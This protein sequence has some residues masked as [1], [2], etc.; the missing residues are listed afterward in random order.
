[1][2]VHQF[3]KE[4]MLKEPASYNFVI[5]HFLLQRRYLVNFWCLAV[6]PCLYASDH[7]FWIG[8]HNDF[9]LSARWLTTVCQ[10]GRFLNQNYV[11]QYIARSYVYVIGKFL[12]NDVSIFRYCF[13]NVDPTRLPIAIYIRT[14]IF[15]HILSHVYLHFVKF[16]LN[17]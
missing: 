6:W 1:M 7:F 14:E 8:T 12:S 10:V 16:T 5:L 3:K 11:V 15:V 13:W 9:W 2:W 4:I 17:F